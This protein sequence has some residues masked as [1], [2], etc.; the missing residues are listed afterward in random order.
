M[1]RVSPRN[2]HQL[3]SVPL[4]LSICSVLKINF[5]KLIS[6]FLIFVFVFK[7]KN[8]LPC[9]FKKASREEVRGFIITSLGC[10]SFPYLMH[11]CL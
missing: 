5:Y 3:V 6:S 11:M 8:T 2:V 7:N 4:S 9:S 1:L 10:T